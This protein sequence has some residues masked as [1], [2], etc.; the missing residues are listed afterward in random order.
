VA[1]G[2]CVSAFVGPNRA[3]DTLGKA[4]HLCLQVRVLS[5]MHHKYTVLQSN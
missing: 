4:T 5:F 1:H 3:N 2:G